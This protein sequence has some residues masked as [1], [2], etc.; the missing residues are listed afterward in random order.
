MKTSN[1]LKGLQSL[2]MDAQHYIYAEIL[3]FY[4]TN[5]DVMFPFPPFVLVPNRELP[6][7]VWDSNMYNGLTRYNYSTPSELMARYNYL[8]K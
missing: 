7:L 5:G 6:D 2:G 1:F 8:I 4:K 3:H